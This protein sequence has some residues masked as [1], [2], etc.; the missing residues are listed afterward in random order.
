MQGIEVVER[1]LGAEREARVV[2]CGGAAA[3]QRL[4]GDGGVRGEGLR[5]ELTWKGRGVST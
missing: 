1:A 3:W 5:A 2:L 4:G